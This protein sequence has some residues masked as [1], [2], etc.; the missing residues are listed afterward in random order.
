MMFSRVFRAH[1]D[2]CAS[3]PWEVIVATLTLTACMLSVGPSTPSVPTPTTT[4][5]VPNA[6]PSASTP[7]VPYDGR[8]PCGWRRDCPGLEYDSVAFEYNAA[9]VIVMTLI[10]CIALLY[11][12]HQFRTLHKMGSKYILGEFRWPLTF[13]LFIF[14]AT[15]IRAQLLDGNQLRENLKENFKNPEMLF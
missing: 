13:P 11:S 14:I 3:H 10:R 2:F 6:P 9:D 15:A 5:P 12:Y 1:G 8:L 4:P 7:A